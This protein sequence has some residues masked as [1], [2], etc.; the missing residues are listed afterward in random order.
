[1]PKQAQM[2]GGGTAPNR[3]AT[4]ALERHG[5]FV[6]RPGQFIPGKDLVH[7]VQHSRLGGS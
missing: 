6:P 1:M 5:W 2:D 7:T 4:L 3:S